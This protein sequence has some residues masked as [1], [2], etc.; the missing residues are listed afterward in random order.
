MTRV[1]EDGH[2]SSCL[3]PGDSVMSPAHHRV[4]GAIHLP[5]GPGVFSRRR[6]RRNPDPG[7]SIRQE[8][9]RMKLTRK[10]GAVALAAVLT[11][12]PAG[13][14]GANQGTRAPKVV[15]HGLDNPRGLT[16]G[17]DDTL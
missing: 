13:P 6:T 5:P 9:W 10:L 12:G 1:I 8:R 3:G 4:L 11:L 16:W 17:P 2:F 15:G 14:A 7:R